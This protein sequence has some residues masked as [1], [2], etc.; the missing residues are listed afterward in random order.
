[1]SCTRTFTLC[2]AALIPMVSIADTSPRE[3]LISRFSSVALPIATGAV[4]EDNKGCFWWV[5]DGERAPEVVALI[6]DQTGKPLCASQQS[7]KVA[8]GKAD[9]GGGERE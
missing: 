6:D 7:T 1:M 5:R 4:L 2:F 9:H 3:E 8:A